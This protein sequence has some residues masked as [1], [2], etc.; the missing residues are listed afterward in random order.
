MEETSIGTVIAIDDDEKGTD[1]TKINFTITG[2][3]KGEGAVKDPPNDLFGI[4][5]DD[6][7]STG[8]GKVYINYDLRGYHGIYNVAIEV[9]SVK[10]KRT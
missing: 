9:G 1:N 8:E 6:G 3:S 7:Y 2:V 5:T 4:K 10:C